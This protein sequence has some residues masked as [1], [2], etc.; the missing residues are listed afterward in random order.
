M[1]QSI[2]KN[3]GE[4]KEYYDSLNPQEIPCP[5]PCN[6]LTGLLRLIALKCIRPDKIVPAVQVH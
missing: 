3:T 4:W 5:P 6:N 2:E 1:R